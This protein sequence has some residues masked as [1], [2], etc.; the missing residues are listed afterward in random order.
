MPGLLITELDR[1]AFAGNRIPYQSI[2]V[3]GGLRDHVHEFPH[4]AGG[5]PEKLGR[6]L[7]EI[8]VTARFSSGLLDPDLFDLWP[9][10]LNQ[11]AQVFERQDT[12]DLQLP[13]IGVIKAY[14][15]N[16]N[17]TLSSALLNGEDVTLAF[18]EDKSSD[19]LV[20]KA[21]RGAVTG[22]YEKNTELQLE[23][24]TIEP[25]PDI[26][27]AINDAANKVKAILEVKDLYGQLLEARIQTLVQLLEY[28]DRHVEELNNPTNYAVLEALHDLWAATV[29]LAE[30]VMGKGI[31]LH[32]WIVPR[33]MTAGEVSTAIFGDTTHAVDVMNLNALED[34]YEIPAGTTIKYYPEAV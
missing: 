22:V 7:Y 20:E 5:A 6:K 32:A 12:Q 33:L 29:D 1:L 25:K 34:P 19:F 11:L 26:F 9:L 17:R 21:L 4:A 15:F 18:R 13:S 16:W 27:D 8:E 3:R 28:A 2:Q 31:D 23:A 14:C 24:D 10:Q 30:D